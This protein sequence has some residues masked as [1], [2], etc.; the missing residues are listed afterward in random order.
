MRAI[1]YVRVSTEEQATEGLSLEAQ[2]E[3][4][5]AYCHAQG[6]RLVAVFED[7]GVSASTLR[8]SGLEEAL[9][10][11]E[12]RGADVLLALK[13][14]RLTRSVVGLYQL[15][16]RCDKAG[17]RLAAVQDALDT[18]SANGRMVT[19]ILAVLAQW[20]REI[21]SERTAAALAHKK[22]NREHVGLPPYGF[23]I[24]ADGRLEA[25]ADELATIQRMKR[26]RRRGATLQAIADK[27]NDEGVS[28][29]RGKWGKTSVSRLVREHLRTRKARYLNRLDGAEVS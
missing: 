3:R 24:G 19:S 10:A 21:V 14:D 26:L 28:A 2:K 12:D 22:R 18:G 8:R 6:W 9:A 16:E 15:V 23:R 25:N 5:A 7:A 27:L 11:V 4:L 29:R 13:L 1:G 20:E 17:V